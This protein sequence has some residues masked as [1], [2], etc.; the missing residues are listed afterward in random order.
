MPKPPKQP[1]QLLPQPHRPQKKPQQNN[2]RLLWPAGFSRGRIPALRRPAGVPTAP[3]T[4]LHLALNTHL[5]ARLASRNTRDTHRPSQTIAA[6]RALMFALIRLPFLLAIAF[7]IGVF[8]ERNAHS[9]R[10]LAAGGQIRAQ[11]CH[12]ADQ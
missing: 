9:E 10:C 6:T 11:L 4:F 1:K 3:A 12:G 7:V 8:Y 2:A 5:A